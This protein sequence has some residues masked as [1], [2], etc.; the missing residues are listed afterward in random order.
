M[1]FLGLTYLGAILAFLYL[2]IAI[3]MLM[4]F[5]QSPLYELPFTFDLVWFK[6]LAG[7]ERLLTTGWNRV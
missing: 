1:R 7:N 2:P 5:N 6:A 4:A 3:M